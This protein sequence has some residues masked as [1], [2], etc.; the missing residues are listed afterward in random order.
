MPGLVPRLTVFAAAAQVGLGIDPAGL[1]PGDALRRKGRQQV[2]VES[3][4]RVEQHGL[5]PVERDPFPV[6]HEHRD[7]GAILAR[8]EDLAGLV[9]P[10]HRTARTGAL[11]TDVAPVATV[12]RIT[13]EGVSCDVKRK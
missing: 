1:D 12:V 11:C 10:R 9:R 4:V 7:P 3:A 6:R 5:A 13:L 8:E 2:D